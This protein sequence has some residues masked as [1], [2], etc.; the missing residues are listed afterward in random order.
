MK[1][2][3]KIALSL[4]SGIL[5]SFVSITEPIAVQAA[6]ISGQN[7]LDGI[8]KSCT[9]Q[10]INLGAPKLTDNDLKVLTGCSAEVMPQLLEALKAKDW[11]V[12][13]IAAHTLGLFGVKAR[14]AIP[15][16]SNLVGDENADVRFVIAKALGKIGGEAVV[17]ALIK[18]LQDKNEN[19]RFVAA[20]SLMKLGSAAKSA[21]PALTK[22]LNDGSW[23]VRSRSAIAF[24]HL[25]PESKELFPTLIKAVEN[26]LA[27]TPWGRNIGRHF[28]RK[29]EIPAVVAF[30]ALA[31]IGSDVAPPLIKRL[32]GNDVLA[33]STNHTLALIEIGSKT[34]SQQ[35]VALLIEALQDQDWTI[36]KNAALALGGIGLKAAIPALV[37]NNDINHW[38]GYSANAAL[39]QIGFRVILGKKNF[40]YKSREKYIPRLG[41]A[42]RDED[43]QIRSIAVA[44]LGLTNSLEAIPYLTKALKDKDWQVRSSAAKAFSGIYSNK[45]ILSIT[46]LTNTLHDPDWRVRRSAVTSIELSDQTIPVLIELL[47]D[48]NENVRLSAAIKLISRSVSPV[49]IIK[50]GSKSESIISILI[51]TLK[52]SKDSDKRLAALSA[53]SW[54]Y[55]LPNIYHSEAVISAIILAL[56]DENELIRDKAVSDLSSRL[57]PH[58]SKTTIAIHALIQS[59]QDGSVRVRRSAAYALKDAGENAVPA[60]IKALRDEN[61]NVRQTAIESLGKIGTQNSISA[62]T[63]ALKD[64]DDFVR[65]TAERILGELKPVTQE[66]IANFQSND[67]QIRRNTT[68]KVSLMRIDLTKPSNFTTLQALTKLLKDLN[69][70]VRASAAAALVRGSTLSRRAV[71]PPSIA[72]SLQKVIPDLIDSL[73]NGDPLARLDAIFVLGA[74]GSEAK[75]SISAIQ[76]ALKDD[77]WLL[78]YGASVT[79]L[80]I[81]SK[82][83]SAV[84]VLAEIFSDI[85]HIDMIDIDGCCTSHD[86]L[87]A[88]EKIASEQAITA[89]I[90]TLEVSDGK[91]RYSYY[92]GESGDRP[93][94]ATHLIKIGRKAIPALIK[95]LENENNRFMVADI[96][97]EIGSETIPSLV[98]VLR[99]NRKLEPVLSVILKD[100]NLDIRRSVI[101]TLG[102]IGRKNSV[103]KPEVIDILTMVMNDNNEHIDIRW[104]AAASLEKMGKATNF[105]VQYNL[106]QPLDESC[107]DVRYIARFTSSQFDLYGG[108]C[109]PFHGGRGAGISELYQQIRALLSGTSSK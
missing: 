98:E 64:E 68:E 3:Q 47:N 60:L 36:R 52:T 4:I 105:F 27:E 54:S 6:E 91:L 84:S 72:S 55:T 109:L 69:P 33:R 7:P 28:K 70:N 45:N 15:V 95:A 41:E 19:V 62:I 81:N 29:N 108:R 14:S 18:A 94:T 101:Y 87:S 63:D 58:R 78:R 100:K 9:G 67:W 30:D 75:S 107:V 13:A 77:N 99:R 89:L 50:L 21:I 31:E 103:S 96:L 22:T 93:P 79:L 102:N 88:L 97:G 12:K 76:E 10:S 26:P 32:N 57:S 106:P 16:L 48:Q 44:A 51:N 37:D 11:K 1:V 34:S 38:G 82:D 43:W 85:S 24:V 53:L 71:L 35:V 46:S 5:L 61:K 17:P 80:K 20:E 73:K 49:S 90:N 66:F 86:E 8:I 92:K 56:Q 65:R 40:D 2:S 42:L 59:L 39:G 104:M 83:E 74:I 23:F 25:A